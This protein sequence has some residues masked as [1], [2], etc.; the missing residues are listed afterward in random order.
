MAVPLVIIRPEP[1]CSASM[2]KARAMHG[3]EVHGFP[4][5]EVAPRS[6]ETALPD[7][8][9]ALL[10]GSAMV[11]RYGGPGLA[12]LKSLPVLAVGE[13]TASAA[14]DA[15][16]AVA[17]TGSSSMQAMLG[18]LPP[19][20]HRLLRLAGEER[21]ALTPPKGVTV[22]ERIVYASLPREMP[23]EMVDFAAQ[24]G[25]SHAAF[26]RSGAA[27]GGGVR[28]PRHSPRALAAGSPVAP[29]R[30]GCGRRLG[31]SRVDSLPR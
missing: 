13:A 10:V 25:H 9:D 3:V 27:S 16:F 30:G 11:F 2:A 22:D 6:W 4:L 29:D 20:H 19:A 21:V 24:S 18:E 26:G 28:A 15:G 17:A 5:F 12:A 7:R 14:R 8:Y 1:G 31:R 23:P